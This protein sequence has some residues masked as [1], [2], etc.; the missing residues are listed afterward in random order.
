[1]RHLEPEI[2]TIYRNTLKADPPQVC[3][4]C[5]WYTKDGVCAEFNESPPETFA[6][7]PGEC[8]LWVWEIPF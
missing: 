7:Q 1:M 8:L 6:D 2:V 5:D 4:T 3:H